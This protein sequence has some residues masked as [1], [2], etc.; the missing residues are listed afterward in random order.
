MH[1]ADSDEDRRPRRQRQQKAAEFFA[2]LEEQE[3]GDH[4]PLW[5]G[6]DA[7]TPCPSN[8]RPA[9][10]TDEDKEFR[11]E[12]LQQ[13]E[14]IQTAPVPTLADYLAGALPADGQE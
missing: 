4:H 5:D 10:E 9:G 14:Q 11:Q 13:Q 12:R 3:G 1:W 6:P 2:D 8:M 7:W